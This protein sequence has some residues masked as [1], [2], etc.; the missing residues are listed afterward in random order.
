MRYTQEEVLQYVSEEDVKFIRLAF[1]DVYGKPKNISVMPGELVRAFSEGISFDASAIRGF[2]GG[3]RSELLLHP[4][5]STLSVLPWRPEHGRVVRMFCGITYPDGRRFEGDTRGLLAEAVKRAESAGVSF[6]IGPKLEFY[7]FKLDELGE[8]TLIPYDNAGYMD[9]APEDK[10]ENVRR[11]I[12]LTLEQMGIF[13]ESSHH[14]AGPGQNEIAFRYSDALTAADNAMTFI[15]AVKTVAARNGLW[16]DLSP[17][18]LK[19]Q[20][21]NGAHINISVR[22][23]DG[24]DML[25]RAMAG[26]LRYISEITAFLDPQPGSYE[27]LGGYKAP[28]YISWAEHD[29]SQLIRVPAAIGARRRIELRSP[30]PTADPYLALA[31]IIDAALCGIKEGLTPPPPTDIGRGGDGS[32]S[33]E[34]LP[35]SLSEATELMRHSELVRAHLP[36]LIISAYGG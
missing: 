16:A 31:L 21:G 11:E 18:P 28:M 17:K 7:L 22:S 10:G 12:C 33:L 15:T 5:P 9:I 20:P 8:R 35:R 19:D 24:S 1:C 34:R 36:Q 13:P 29:R 4:D 32:A 2:G 23:R 3:G 6:D 14:E 27:R 30:D 25:P 26:I